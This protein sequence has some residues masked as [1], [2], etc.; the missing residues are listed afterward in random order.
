MALYIA[1]KT[2]TPLTLHPGT[3][4]AAKPHAAAQ[5]AVTQGLYLDDSIPVH[6]MRP[7]G[8]VEAR[9]AAIIR[10][11][12]SG[13]ANPTVR[14][15]LGASVPKAKPALGF[16]KESYVKYVSAVDAARAHRD[17][18]ELFTDTKT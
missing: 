9:A 17:F 2:L 11:R 4:T 3:I 10:E 13:V 7:G 14:L 6:A 18:P 5:K 15:Y 16:T 8:A 1:V 12:L